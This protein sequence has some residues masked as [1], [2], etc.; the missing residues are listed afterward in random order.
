[1]TREPFKIFVVKLF[2][3]LFGR[4]ITVKHGFALKKEIKLNVLVFR[5][6]VSR[7]MFE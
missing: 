2:Y 7:K 5:N 3:Q 6:K 4:P 1:M